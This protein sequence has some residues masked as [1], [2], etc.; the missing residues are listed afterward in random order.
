VDEAALVRALRDGHLFAAGLDV[1]EHEPAVHEG[2]LGL[3]NV[4][5]LPH[6][7]SADEDTRRGMAML[8]ADN[9]VSFVT[10]GTPLTRV[11]KT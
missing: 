6:I 1:Y 4:V 2:L 7:G 11:R 3:E 10:T 8:A 5:L 9:V